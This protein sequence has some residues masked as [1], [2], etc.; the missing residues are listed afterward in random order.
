MRLIC[1]VVVFCMLLVLTA[2]SD[3]SSGRTSAVPNAPPISNAGVDQIVA[4]LATVTLDGSGSSDVEDDAQSTALTYL[5]QQTDSTNNPVTLS[6]NNAQAVTFSAPQL[7]QTA[8]LTFNLTVTD[9]GGKTHH[10]S[11]NI[12]VQ[13]Y[14]NAPVAHAGID[15]AVASLATVTLNGAASSDVEDDAQSTALTY[16]WQQ[17]DSTNNPVTLSANNAQ[18]VTFSAPQL[19]QA[20]ILTFNLT[21]TDSGGKTHHDSINITVQ[22][23]NNAPVA[24][25]GSD[26]TVTSL[27][28]VT[29]DGTAGSDIEDDA[30]STALTYLW[31]Q[32]G[33][34]SNAIT[35]SDVNVISPTFAAPYLLND[36]VVTLS[37]TVTDSGGKANADSVNISIETPY[38][39][40]NDT[41][42]T[43]CSDATINGFPCPVS[44]FDGQDGESGRDVTLNDDSDGHAGFSFTKLDANGNDL[45]ASATQWSCVRDNVTGYI[46]EVKTDDSGL[47]DKDNTYTWYNSTGIND[48]GS[49]G[50]ENGGSCPDGTNCDTEKYVQAVNA[51]NLCGS[52]DWRFPARKTLHSIIDYSRSD[53]AVDSDYF[54]YAGNDSY[55]SSSPGA[56]GID[57]AW[58]V[59]FSF[60]SVD[61]SFKANAGHVRLVRGG[62]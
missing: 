14:N 17:T 47:R 13:A 19:S 32:T 3:S 21:V 49:A 2:C 28:T 30:K 62:Q 53:V 9:S 11:I 60:G 5:W 36:V 40:F 15:Q 12:T 20:T 16:L 34:L 7:S 51:T 58:F 57:F 29:L 46:W 26:Q 52:N 41:G 24:N 31:Q 23:Y 22:A 61:L 55:W 45:T 10:D 44:G 42:I 8:I 27:A 37:L 4:S 43:T 54:P 25:A 39:A 59:F 56:Y 33:D 1:L 18:G 6:A 50:I 35:L 38:Q 48:G